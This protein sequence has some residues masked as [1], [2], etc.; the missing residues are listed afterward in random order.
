MRFKEK[1]AEYGSGGGPLQIGLLEKN[2]LLSSEV[3]VGLKI[4]KSSSNLKKIKRY[5]I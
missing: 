3:I 4:K 2:L 1:C 5:Q